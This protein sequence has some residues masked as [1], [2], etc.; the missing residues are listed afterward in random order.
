MQIDC[1]SLLIILWVGNEMARSSKFRFRVIETGKPGF[2][3]F[4]IA[5]G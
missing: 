2:A 5:F 3:F 4:A 1:S